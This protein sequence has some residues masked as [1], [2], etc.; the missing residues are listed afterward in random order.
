MGI[1]PRSYSALW[2]AGSSGKGAHGGDIALSE[3]WKRPKEVSMSEEERVEGGRQRGLWRRAGIACVVVAMVGPIACGPCTPELPAERSPQALQEEVR[4]EDDAAC[5]ALS[6]ML[7]DVPPARE[8]VALAP[9]L[10]QLETLLTEGGERAVRGAAG[11]E[12]DPEAGETQ[13][14]VEGADPARARLPQLLDSLARANMDAFLETAEALVADPRTRISHRSAAAA[15]LARS[16]P[17]GQALLGGLA[18]ASLEAGEVDHVY[19]NTIVQAVLRPAAAPQTLFG[20]G[21]YCGVELL[22]PGCDV[23][24]VDLWVAGYALAERVD[25]RAPL[26]RVAAAEAA[27]LLDI[28][29]APAWAA[30]LQEAVA[31]GRPHEALASLQRNLKTGLSPDVLHRL[32]LFFAREGAFRGIHLERTLEAAA[33]QPA[34]VAD[35]VAIFREG[36][37]RSL[38][39]GTPDPYTASLGM[40]LSGSSAGF[41]GA[42]LRQAL[43]Q[44]LRVSRPGPSLWMGAMELRLTG[45]TQGRLPGASAGMREMLAAEDPAAIIAWVEEET[46]TLGEVQLLSVVWSVDRREAWVDALNGAELR[47]PSWAY[48]LVG[49]GAAALPALQGWARHQAIGDLPL[50]VW[51]ALHAETPSLDPAD[52]RILE[53]LLRPTQVPTRVRETLQALRV[54][55]SRPPTMVLWRLIEQPMTERRGAMETPYSLAYLASA[56]MIHAGLAPAPEEVIAGLDTWGARYY[57]GR[58]IAILAAHA[59]RQCQARRR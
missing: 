14:Q 31:N 27:M 48:A 5:A 57:G 13:R 9:L 49:L 30:A 36:W 50:D 47:S 8:A 52:Q 42:P 12:G 37:R 35:E 43:T 19:R 59:A 6:A 21:T 20:P 7:L 34:H 29:Q 45:A 58:E 56:T 54:V 3:P 25:E 38:D 10:V 24:A 2:G 41:D 22:A 17:R 4:G 39:A 26:V 16:G 18:L 53:D 11:A 44:Q 1:R 28:H 33:L 32:S 46:P 15:A 40:A 55:R 23:L 51:W